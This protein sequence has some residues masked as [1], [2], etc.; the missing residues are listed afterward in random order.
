AAVERVDAKVWTPAEAVRRFNPAQ[1]PQLL[2]PRLTDEDRATPLATGLGVSPGAASGEIVFTPDDA[3]RCRARGRHCILVVMETGP[4]DIE[5]MKAATG[6]LTARGGMTSH[7]AVVARITGKPCVAALRNL[8]VKPADLSCTIGDRTFRAG[9]VLTI[10][11]SDGSVYAGARPLKLP[12]LG[13][14]LQRLLGWSDA[15]RRVAVRAN[16]ETVESATT[17]LGFG[18]EGIGL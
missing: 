8:A 7:A 17:A 11:G 9:E 2:H 15:N 10:D 6:I 18:A 4:G 5:G 16:A 12:H 1:L 13:T 14:S 3:A